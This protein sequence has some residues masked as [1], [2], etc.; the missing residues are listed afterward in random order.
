MRPLPIASSNFQPLCTIG[1]KGKVP[2]GTNYLAL[3]LVCTGV[4]NAQRA[5]VQFALWVP[6]VPK[7]QVQL[8]PK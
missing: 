3:V 1:L 6:I 4:D 8:I 2:M 7:V 5:P